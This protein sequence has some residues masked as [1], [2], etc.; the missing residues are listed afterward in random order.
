MPKICKLLPKW[1]NFAKSGHT[2]VFP[3]TVSSIGVANCWINFANYWIR[4]SVLCGLKKSLCPLCHKMAQHIKGIN[5]FSFCLSLVDFVLMELFFFWG[6]SVAIYRNAKSLKHFFRE[7]E[8][9]LVE[10][11]FFNFNFLQFENNCFLL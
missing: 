5:M 8:S 6:V 2:V 4:T 3:Q 1:R 11:F 7:I 10:T 9:I